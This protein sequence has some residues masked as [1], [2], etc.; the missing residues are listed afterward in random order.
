MLPPWSYW[1]IIRAPWKS[2]TVA[3]LIKI[4]NLTFMHNVTPNR[5]PFYL[6]DFWKGVTKRCRLSC[7]TN[8][9]LIYE[10]EWG[11]GRLRGLRKWVQPCTG[12]QINFGDLTPYLTFDLWIMKPG[13]PADDF[14]YLLTSL[15]LPY[16]IT[17]FL[18]ASLKLLTN[19]E[20]AYWNP[21]RNSSLCDWSM[22]SS[23]SLSFAAGKLRKN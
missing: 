9:A 14:M 19:F 18:F 22:F 13:S 15:S 5:L 23:A 6:N 7:L 12:A 3:K 20:N 21:P 11:G 1:P 8:S 2:S 4:Y 10:P 17:N 16:T